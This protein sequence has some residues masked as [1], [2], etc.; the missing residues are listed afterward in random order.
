MTATL[1]LMSAYV[2]LSQVVLYHLCSFKLKESQRLMEQLTQDNR[3]DMVQYG[4][5]LKE[6]GVMLGV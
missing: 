6:E 3:R 2:I 5:P 4:R 1:P